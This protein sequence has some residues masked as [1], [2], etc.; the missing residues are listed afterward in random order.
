MKP[1]VPLVVA[2]VLFGGDKSDDPPKVDRAV[3]LELQ[4]LQGTWQVEAWEAGSWQTMTGG[5]TEQF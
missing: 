3:A 2:A 4:R 1:L 5:Y